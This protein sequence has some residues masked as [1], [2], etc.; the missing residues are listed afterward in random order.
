MQRDA[1]ALHEPGNVLRARI[2]IKLVLEALH[3]IGAFRRAF[4]PR[5]PTSG[6]IISV[7]AYQSGTWRRPKRPRLLAIGI[8]SGP[9]KREPMMRVVQDY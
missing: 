3:R 6:F 1:S 9:G 5:P 2:A 8:R 7:E 4:R